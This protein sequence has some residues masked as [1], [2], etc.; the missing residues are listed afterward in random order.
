M[1]RVLT[2]YPA[3]R[4]ASPSTNERNDPMDQKTKPGLSLNMIANPGKG[5]RGGDRPDVRGYVCL[6][7]DLDRRFNAALYTGTYNDKKTGEERLYW[8]GKADPFARSDSPS[9]KF[10]ANNARRARE[11]EAFRN[12]TPVSDATITLP[13]GGTLEENSILIFEKSSEFKGKAANG[14]TKTDAYGYWNHQGKLIEIGGWMPEAGITTSI[15]GGT[16]HPLTNEQRVAMG[17]KPLGEQPDTFAPM[18]DTELQQMARDME[19][20]QP[21][22]DRLGDE[23]VIP[24]GEED[25]KPGKRSRAGR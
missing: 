15:V 19:T 20:F 17:Y 2:E 6:P 23:P 24:F 5:A 21:E 16:Q 10:R 7:D 8:K 12:G 22:Q 9:D 18:S 4:E 1:H 25:K 14:K 11:A 3:F 13:T